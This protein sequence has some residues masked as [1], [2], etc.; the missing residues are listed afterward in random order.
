MPSPHFSREGAAKEYILAPPPAAI[1]VALAATVMN[2]PVRTLSNS[3]PAIPPAGIVQESDGA[4]F[5]KKGHA[6]SQDVLFQPG[7]Y[8]DAGEVTP[9][10]RAVETLPGE[11]LLED[12]SPA[13]PV[14]ETPQRLQFGN[15]PGRLVDQQP[16]QFLVVDEPSAAN[17]VFEMPLEGILWI[18]DRVIAALHHTSAAAL[19]NLTL[20]DDHDIQV[21]VFSVGVQGR[22][23]PG[24][25]AADYQNIRV[26]L[27]PHACLGRASG[28]TAPFLPVLSHNIGKIRP[29]G[30]FP[31]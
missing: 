10:D 7:H 3:A 23:Q 30:N 16:G 20:G 13:V 9:V 4:V 27:F 19:A 22:H 1:R 24:T 29:G 15:N 6:G 5:V 18:Q 2:S 17:S 8:L 31:S 26:Q 14:E 12:V 11:S 21:G 25:A 28:G